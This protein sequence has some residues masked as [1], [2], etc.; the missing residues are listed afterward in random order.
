MK[1]IYTVFVAALLALVCSMSA[2][3]QGG[4]LNLILNCDRSDVVQWRQ[5]WVEADWRTMQEG[6]NQITLDY[7]YGYT[8]QLRTIDGYRLDAVKSPDSDSY[9]DLNVSNPLDNN[10][11]YPNAS[12]E[13]RTYNIVTSDL[14]EVRSAKLTVNVVDNPNR[15]TIRRST[16]PAVKLPSTGEHEFRFDPATELPLVISA[17]GS[18]PLYKVLLDNEPVPLQTNSS[19]M[20]ELKNLSDGQRL[21]IT[22]NWPADIKTGVSITVPEGL[23]GVVTRIAREL[24][25][26][27]GSEDVEFTVNTPFK[28]QGGSWYSIYL[29]KN[30]YVIDKLLINGTSQYVSASSRFW[31]GDSDVKIDIEAKVKVVPKYTI[32]TARDNEVEYSLDGYSF[33]KLPGGSTEIVPEEGWGGWTSVYLRAANGFRLTKVECAEVGDSYEIPENPSEFVQLKPTADWLGRVYVV[34]AKNLE[35][36]RTASVTVTVTDDPAKVSVAKRGNSSIQLGEAGEAKTITFNPESAEKNFLFA[37]SLVPL[38]SV[39]VNGE[40]VMPDKAESIEYTIPV[41]DGDQIEIT[42][43]YP[44]TEIPVTINID[45]DVAR[46]VSEVLR[47]TGTNSYDTEEI[48]F[49]PGEPFNVPAGSK[50]SIKYDTRAFNLKSVKI[51]DRELKSNS[52]IFVLTEPVVIDIDAAEWRVLSFSIKVND[53]EQ[54]QVYP[55]T[56]AW[57]EPYALEAGENHFTIDE[58]EGY[59]TLKAKSGFQVNSVKDANGQLLLPV[60]GY[61]GVYKVSEPDM[62]FDIETGDI[63][64]DGQWVMWIDSADN[65]QEDSYWSSSEFRG[66]SHELKAGYTVHSY[67]SVLEEQFT[68]VAYLTKG[69]YLY[70]NGEF[71]SKN[72]DYNNNCY[73]YFTPQNKIDVLRMYTTGE[74]AEAYKLT[75]TVSDDKAAATKVVT[76]LIVEQ[77]EWADGLTLLEGTRVSLTLPADMENGTV[78]LDDTPLEADEDGNYV[79]DTTGDHNVT[80]SPS[81]SILDLDV[82]KA[83]DNNTVYNTLGVKVLENAS[84]SDLK[85]LPAGI[86]VI[87]GQKRVVR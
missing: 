73:Q 76:D 19:S 17:V 70:L 3:A 65:L 38:N 79:F 53:P 68:F 35:E 8:L 69:F 33:G 48:L 51:G 44:E 18:E 25:N 43:G 74:P 39:K 24:P 80:I 10:Y 2:S 77:P 52:P 27:G 14:S 30:E 11:F 85:R 62:M 40:T 56:S 58:R 64:Y 26:Y 37:G 4:P 75:F 78:K 36:E 21:D 13:G 49:T 6:D 71:F 34:E 20:Y 61:T 87:N 60:E 23:E 46:A 82:E 81:S 29:N 59:I 28:V 72:S 22:S 86:Y 1:K 66:E 31:V 63:Q 47:Y 42:A 15:F 54:I 57:G 12:W 5:T 41:A 45:A 55:G 84:A 67:A 50:L 83:S 7:D 9:T 32:S 16:G